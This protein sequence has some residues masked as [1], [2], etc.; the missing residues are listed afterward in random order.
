MNF[1][2]DK[3]GLIF[4]LK[5]LSGGALIVFLVG[6]F[7]NLTFSYA[8]PQ[9]YSKQ[10]LAAA[11]D[12]L[13]NRN[14]ILLAFVGDIMLGRKVKESILKNGGGDFRYPFEKIY[15]SLNE[16]DILFGNLEGPIS[17]KGRDL[18]SL[19]SFR[20][21]PK[22]A[23]GL[24]FAGF[25]ILSLANN[26]IG[27][28]GEEAIDDTALRLERAGIVS[29]GRDYSPKILNIHGVKIAFLAFF[30]APEAEIKKS[31]E[32]AKLNADIVVASFHFGD[33]YEKAP[34]KFQKKIALLAVD[35]GANLVIGHHPHI[36]QPIEEYNGGYIAYSLGNFVFDQDFS[37]D[38]MRGA[39]LEVELSDKR[40]ARIESKTIV[41]NENFQPTQPR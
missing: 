29:V 5:A 9:I 23:E 2:L 41:I 8:Y 39:L 22:A 35:A 40:I 15:R 13:E 33:E 25:D 36:I 24:A 38:T 28:W 16:Y 11:L 32:F 26:H 21:D 18:G 20:M 10:N 27:D 37:E 3:V 6:F 12:P 34:N 31:V 14:K 1:T 4:T 19:Y 30:N 7:S 17:D